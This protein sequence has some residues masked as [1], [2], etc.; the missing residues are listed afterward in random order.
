MS[1]RVKLTSITV[2][3]GII[4]V[5]VLTFFI[6]RHNQLILIEN[7]LAANTDI[8]VAISIHIDNYLDELAKTTQTLATTPLIKTATIESNQELEGHDIEVI[9]E[10]IK[11]LNNRW[12]TIE[13]A[14]DPFIQ[15][16]L[17]NA[18][19][20]HLENQKQIIPD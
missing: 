3:L 20:K 16:Y 14:N 4:V 5:L 1:F 7:T 9:K 18:V 19:A 8:A 13:D 11:G 17:T 15:K 2:A 6:T 10:Q 12:I